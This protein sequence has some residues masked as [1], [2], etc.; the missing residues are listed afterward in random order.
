MKDENFGT[1]S[2]L[3]SLPDMADVPGRRDW[4]RGV[5]SCIGVEHEGWEVSARGL[6]VGTCLGVAADLKML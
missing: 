6:A 2:F 5:W 4:E 3:S 1:V